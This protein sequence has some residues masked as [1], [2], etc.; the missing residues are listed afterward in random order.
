MKLQNHDQL[1]YLEDFI[2]DECSY[3]GVYPK[4]ARAK[5]SLRAP[6]VAPHDFLVGGHRYLFKKSFI[7]YPHQ[8]WIEIAA[9]RIGCL[10]GVS[11]PP[12]FVAYDAY[13]T[14]FGALIE[15]FYDYPGSQ[16][17]AYHDGGVY[18]QQLIENYDMKV[19]VKHNFITISILMKA[20]HKVMNEK[21]AETWA[22]IFTFDAIIGNTD[23]HHDNWGIIWNVEE[24]ASD[25]VTATIAP[26]FDNGTSLGHEIIEKN[27][28]KYD[29]RDT[30][31]RYILRGKHHARWQ[32]GDTERL[33]HAEFLKKFTDKY[34]DTLQIVFDCLKFD[35]SKIVEIIYQLTQFDV[36]VPLT[37]S[38]AEFMVKLVETR[39]HYLLRELGAVYEC[40][41]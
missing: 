41:Y 35:S 36:V 16:K 33:S 34:P 11:V 26:A 38:R 1:V 29:S 8:F 5:K 40:Y 17:Q 37:A 4:G 32:I 2:D 12:T 20:L 27:I 18:M 31:E 13:E 24:F 10:M 19:G 9:Y 21:W 3:E 6:S 22:K 15:W 14:E 39:R 25:K 30:M 28:S 23:R 7:R